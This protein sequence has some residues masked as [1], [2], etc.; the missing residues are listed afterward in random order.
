MKR[1]VLGI[2]SNQ[3]D[4][5]KIL[6]CA[7]ECIHRLPKTKVIKISSVYKTVPLGYSNQPDFLNA[8]ILVETQLTPS[9]LLGACLGIEAAYHRMRS[10]PNGPRTL[11]IDLILMEDVS[12]NTEELILP[13]PRF[14]ERAFVLVPLFDIFPEGIALGIPFVKEMYE[15][16]DQGIKM[17]DFNI[18]LE[19][20]DKL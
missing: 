1:A 8:V 11:D 14:K 13:H 18:N 6:R 10:F 19:H 7:V 9:A 2:G 4:S 5:I 12:S 3:G 16:K 15:V 20:A 17:T